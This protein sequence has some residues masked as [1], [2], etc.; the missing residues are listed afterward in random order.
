MVPI[1]TRLSGNGN[2]DNASTA[3]HDGFLI[4]EVEI[5]QT[6][7]AGDLLGRLVSVGGEP[8][9]EYRAPVAGVVALTREFP[10]VRAGDG[11]FLLTQ[12]EDR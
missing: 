1:T 10:V 2:I 4:K 5:L 11:L 3:V 7:A 6:V 9:E 8:I 12:K